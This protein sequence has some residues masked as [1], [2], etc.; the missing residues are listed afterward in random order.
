M[1]TD[2]PKN[3]LGLARWI[4]SPQN[5]LFARVTVNRVWQ[6]IFGT[7]LVKTTDDFGVQGEFPSHPELLDYLAVEFRDG[8]GKCGAFRV[9][10]LMELIVTS[11]TYRQSSAGR[12]DLLGKDPDDRLLGRFPRRRLT[13]EE[14]RDQALF[15]AGLLSPKLGGPAVLPYQPAGLW[16]ERSNEGSNTKNYKR[17]EGE[18]LYRRSLYT[19]W[20]RTCPPP[21][22]SVFDAPD[23]LNCTARR[24]AT[25]TPLQALATL[26][27]EQFL[28]CA[29]LLAVRSLQDAKEP[30]ARLVLLVRRA[31]GRTPDAADLKILEKGLQA[32]LVR[33]RA[34]PADAEALLRQGATPAPATLD[35]PELAAWMLVA[36]AVLNL[37]ATIMRD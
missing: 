1:P 30:Q 27:D 9:K 37:D 6:R 29:K 33:Y 35:K 20:K 21:V 18:S 34:A 11:A 26:N 23:R 10:H 22:M 13:A 24:A 8:D 4:V 3:R 25:N 12:A 28:E 2:L 5:P 32:L 14:V 16:E 36:S 15:A 19:F 17:S 7:G 31:T